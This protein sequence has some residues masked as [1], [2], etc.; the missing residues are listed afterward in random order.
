[1]CNFR[2]GQKVVLVDDSTRGE[3]LPAKVF[4]FAV[5][6]RG[7]VYTVRFVGTVGFGRKSVLLLEEINN[8]HAAMMLGLVIEPALA[9]D[10]FRPVV[11][12]KTD[13]E[14]FRRMLN[15]TPETVGAA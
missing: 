11:E 9:A 6:R 10:R 12:R 1:M 4:G 7:E 15:T 3:G 13:I 14:I 2:V 8:H 5:P